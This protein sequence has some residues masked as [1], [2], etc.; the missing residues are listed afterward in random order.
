LLNA[1]RFLREFIQESHRF[2]FGNVIF[3]LSRYLQ[4]PP[5]EGE[6]PSV[7]RKQLPP[8]KS[9]TPFDVEDKWVLT[10]SAM[11]TDGKDLSQVKK[12]VEEL[13][14]VK[15]DFEGCFD[16]QVLDRHIFDTRVKFQ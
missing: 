6:S 4:L 7:I 8:F 10:A 2:I 9:L 5:K 1:H 16:L 13:E 3:E 12:G 15:S 11:V 14:A